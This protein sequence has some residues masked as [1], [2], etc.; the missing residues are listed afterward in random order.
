MNAFRARLAGAPNYSA[1]ALNWK[2]DITEMRAKWDR[3]DK[4]EFYLYG[5]SW[6]QVFVRMSNT[7]DQFE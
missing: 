1:V 5:K 7:V 3:G 4:K 6:K 2:I